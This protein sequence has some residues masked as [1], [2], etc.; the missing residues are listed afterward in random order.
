MC[1][2]IGLFM[3]KYIALC[4]RRTW[5]KKCISDRSDCNHVSVELNKDL[6]IAEYSA[7][8]D[9][10]SKNIDIME[11]FE[12][13]SVGAIAASMVFLLNLCFED[14]NFIEQLKNHPDIRRIFLIPFVISLFGLMKFYSLDSVIG[15]Y[16]DYLE[17]LEC[18]YGV[19]GLTTHFRK[20]NKS[21]PISLRVIHYFFWGLLMVFSI[22]FYFFVMQIYLI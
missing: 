17:K 2:K 7:C 22:V 14:I 1:K 13:Y 21:S 12:I 18:T 4:K 6:I 19:L 16:N 11:K 20:W 8:R 15:V 9:I 10:L 5:G 3:D